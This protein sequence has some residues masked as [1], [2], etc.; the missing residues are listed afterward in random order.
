[1]MKYM[2]L[3]SMV[4]AL[5]FAVSAV[6]AAGNAITTSDDVAVQ[7]IRVN[8]DIYDQGRTLRVDL[9]EQL[10]IRVRL[11]AFADARDIQ[12]T[13]ELFGYE[14]SHRESTRDSSR[15]IDLRAGD[16]DSVN[17]GLQ[18]PI[19]AD[20]DV[21][22]LVI[23]V[24]SRGVTYERVAFD[25]RVSGPRHGILV[26]DVLFSPNN[27]VVAGR[28]LLTQ[29][30]LENIGERTQNDVKVTVKI[31]A[32]GISQ[33]SFLDTIHGESSL[34]RGEQRTSEEIFVR[35]PECAPEGLYAVQIEVSY[36]EFEVVTRNEQILIAASDLCGVGTA[37]PEQPAGRTVITA[38]QPQSV[39]AGVGG[40]T[41]PIVIQNQGNTARTYTVS[42]SGI[43][44]WGTYQVSDSA[45]TVGAG[46]TGVVYVFVAAN[47]D[48]PQGTQSF[49]V[50]VASGTSKESFLAQVTVTEAQRTSNTMSYLY[51]VLIVL[52]IILII[53]G[54]IVVFAKLS[55]KDDDMDK[56]QAYY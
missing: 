31:P 46:Q 43:S 12:V 4:I 41:Y 44:N 11:E 19:R 10:D 45:I 39:Q 1:M 6:S 56:G 52:I 28:S 49:G 55:G 9:G 40:A 18:I 14:F 20:K 24:A 13:A 3:I 51:I 8:G 23:T 27:V 29:V 48:A 34:G 7:S 2:H 30:R 50:E 16:T 38:P 32:L 54:F 15:L 33:S 22:S 37:Q 21:Y 53:L 5:L 42:V 25:V 47:R 35:I 36:N 26:R 17:L